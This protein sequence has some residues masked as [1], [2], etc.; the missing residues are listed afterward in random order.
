MANLSKP[1]LVNVVEQLFLHVDKIN[2]PKG[3]RVPLEDLAAHLRL[4]NHRYLAL[5]FHDLLHVSAPARKTLNRWI[6]AKLQ[7]GGISSTRD[8]ST[9]K[10]KGKA[11]AKAKAKQEV[12]FHDMYLAIL[13]E[14]RARL[15]QA[16]SDMS[17]TVFA[18]ASL[19]PDLAFEP[20]DITAA[21]NKDLE[22]HGG[23]GLDAVIEEEEAHPDGGG[24]EHEDDDMPEGGEEQ[25]EEDELNLL[26]GE[27]Q[28]DT[29]DGSKPAANNSTPPVPAASAGSERAGENRAL[30]SP[31]S[32]RAPHHFN[33]D[34]S[35]LLGESSFSAHR[36]PKQ[37]GAGQHQS[38]GPG[39][40]PRGRLSDSFGMAFSDPAPLPPRPPRSHL[41]APTSTRGTRSAPNATPPP[42]PPLESS[43]LS[44]KRARS[45]A[46]SGVF[47]AKDPNGE[48]SQQS[49]AVWRGGGGASFSSRSS[50]S[51]AE[52]GEAPVKKRARLGTTTVSAALATQSQL[53]TRLLGSSSSTGATGSTLSSSLDIL[54][55]KGL[56]SL[57][58][59]RRLCDEVINAILGR[60]S[61]PNIGVLSSSAIEAPERPGENVQ[62]CFSTKATV[63]FPENRNGKHWRLWRWLSADRRLELYDSLSS[64]DVAFTS[65]TCTQAARALMLISKAYAANSEPLDPDDVSLVRVPCAQQD[66]SNDCGVYAIVFATSLASPLAMTKSPLSRA[67]SDDAAAAVAGASFGNAR[68]ANQNNDNDPQTRPQGQDDAVEIVFLP[69][70]PCDVKADIFRQQISWS[71]FSGTAATL[72]HLAEDPLSVVEICHLSTYHS[73]LSSTTARLMASSGLQKTTTTTRTTQA[74]PSSFSAACI[75]HA[76]SAAQES[77]ARLQY[78]GHVFAAQQLHRQHCAEVQAAL[79]SDAR[80]RNAKGALAKLREA[81]GT[82]EFLGRPDVDGEAKARVRDAAAQAGLAWARCV[83]WILL[84]HRCA[85]RGPGS[86]VLVFPGG[87]RGR[88]G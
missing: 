13:E 52:A 58:P 17:H 57:K 61:T 50:A 45:A 73:S 86:L 35:L 85:Q 68:S 27:Y 8:G 62:Q 75:A 48:P 19:S 31:R 80:A 28:E 15:G 34:A 51:A 5:F 81:A 67:L 40:G 72:P 3:S 18:Y 53:Q 84:A 6:E 63:L 16:A 32:D 87:G 44:R 78:G 55:K 39:P 70:H 42:P 56:R 11:K 14:R 74:P 23:A 9:A 47:Q 54:A 30:E 29:V 21:F 69:Q 7:R 12:D 25:D 82:F 88:D 4:P 77:W 20:A 33:K 79:A 59:G 36:V 38:I 46:Q 26:P 2:D 60:L 71:L 65:L 10:C 24:F 66:N 22:L 49:G 41:H 1:C 43:A 64:G 37:G 83:A 76:E